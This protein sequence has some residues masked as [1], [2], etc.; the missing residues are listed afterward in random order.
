MKNILLILFLSIASF[1]LGQTIVPIENLKGSVT[2]SGQTYY[3]KDVNGVFDKFI[4]DWRYQDSEL[5][6]SK[7]VEIS[8][9]KRPMVMSGTG[10]RYYDEIYALIK[11]THNGTVVYNTYPVNLTPLLIEE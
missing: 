11:Y 7:V 1:S 8:F 4:G 3:Y 6:P 2:T 9:F 10:T 5:N